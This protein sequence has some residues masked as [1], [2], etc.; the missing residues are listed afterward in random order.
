MIRNPALRDRD[1]RRLLG[2]AA[3][4]QQGMSGEQVVIGLLV[5][6]ATGSTAW[7]GIIL[8][9]YFLPFFVFGL[10]SGTV[11]DWIDR[12]TLLRRLELATAAVLFV[13]AASTAQEETPIWITAAFTLLVGSLRALHQPVRSSYAYDLMGQEN[14]VSA[15][16]LLN[17]GSRSGQLLGALVAGFVMESFG[18]S[19]ALACLGGGHLIAFLFFRSLRAAGVAAV[20]ER[21][22]IR[23]NI[24]EYLVELGTN[25]L[26]LTLLAVTASVEIFGFSF[27]T[28][29]PE[30]AANRLE[31]GAEGLGWL[32]GARAFA[33]IIAGVIFATFGVRSRTGAMYLSIIF[34]FGVFMTLLSQPLPLA[35]T[36][37]AVFLLSFFAASCDIMAQSMMQLSVAN[38][39]RGRAMGIWV[40]ALGFGPLGHLEL[41]AVA[42][43][44]GLQIGLLLN[45]GI[46]ILIAVMTAVLVP[47]LRQR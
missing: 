46:L 31:I 14:L 29:L 15:M 33:G 12:R 38:D 21:A 32:Q 22:P 6:E 3:F 41:G 10:L 19:A 30:I 47:R 11:A 20:A 1:Y 28:A 37:G 18:G 42:G 26:L 8:A 2:G 5:Y 17:I 16:G 13:F 39:L 7:V 24:R 25:R 27:A 40:L 44:F 36:L 34:M 23:Q 45:G 9:I 43:A 4:H 35:L